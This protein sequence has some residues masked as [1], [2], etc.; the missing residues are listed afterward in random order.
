MPETA[1]ISEEVILSTAVMEAGGNIQVCW[2]SPF[3]VLEKRPQAV[4]LLRSEA[5]GTAVGVWKIQRTIWLPEKPAV[6]GCERL[7][8][9]EPGGKMK[10]LVMSVESNTC[11][12][13]VC[14]AVASALKLPA[15]A[16]TSKFEK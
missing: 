5:G 9:K 12:L 15:L 7:P 11:Q 10:L 6:S 13:P 2:G 16:R 14:R 1:S 8:A 3:M 4:T